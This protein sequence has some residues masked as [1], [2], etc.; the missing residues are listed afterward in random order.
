MS[1]VYDTAPAMAVAGGATWDDAGVVRLCQRGDAGAFRLLVA[2]H[3]PPILALILNLVRDR[4]DADDL[5]QEVFIK[6]YRSISR[7]QRRSQVSTWLYRIALNR[8]T[9]WL[10]S[11]RRQREM[12]PLRATLPGEDRFASAGGDAPDRSLIRAELG[13]AVEEA[14]QVL[15]AS[16]R[17]TLI[18]REQERLS[19]DEIAGEMNCSVGTVKSRLF[20]ARN[21]MQKALAGLHE[22]WKD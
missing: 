15:P 12:Y 2:R 9:D 1:S 16:C 19:Y 14:M 20:R 8:C 4:D 13:R 6:A 11:R 21:Q 7:F 18:L 17:T 5:V 10:R 22:E 3:H